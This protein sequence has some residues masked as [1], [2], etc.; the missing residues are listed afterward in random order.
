[1]IS[2]NR[3]SY[4]RS[5]GMRERYELNSAVTNSISKRCQESRERVKEL[6]V[7]KRQVRNLVPRLCTLTLD[8][9]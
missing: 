3:A 1:M 2:E 8:I 7:E 9:V 5:I 4:I 6:K